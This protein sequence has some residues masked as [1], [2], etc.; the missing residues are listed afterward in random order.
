MSN[1]NIPHLNYIGDSIIGEN[2]NFGAGTKIANL[3]LDEKEI[4]VS[5]K[6]ERIST[7][8]KK[9]GAIVGDGVKTGINVSINVGTMIGSNVHIA[10]HVKVEGYIEPFARVF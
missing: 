10:P 8:R 5:V 3:R 2:C 7:G 9:F 6:G 4:Y 1:T